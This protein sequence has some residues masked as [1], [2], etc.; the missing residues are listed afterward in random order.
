MES[1]D[2]SYHLINVPEKVLLDPSQEKKEKKKNEE[3]AISREELVS[4]R[5]AVDPLIPLLGR[6]VGGRTIEKEKER[7]IKKGGRYRVD[8]TCWYYHT[9]SLGRTLEYI[10]C[11]ASLGCA[12][13][14]WTK[15]LAPGFVVNCFS[16]R[17][18]FF[19][20]LFCLPTDHV[21]MQQQERRLAN[22]LQPPVSRKNIA[23]PCSVAYTL[24]RN[25]GIIEVY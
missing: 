19:S 5:E 24:D 6:T 17:F 20:S 14:Y 3:P 4:H 16:P 23:F 1:W 2:R 18:L 10:G 9:C 22:T 11:L 13:L 12:L 21:T 7:K 25:G 15:P 8:A